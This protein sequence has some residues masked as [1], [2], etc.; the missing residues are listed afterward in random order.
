M[1]TIFSYLVSPGSGKEGTLEHE[2]TAINDPGK[3]RDMLESVFEGADDE[4]TTPIAFS[5]PNGDQS[6]DTRT[7]LIGAIKSPTEA[8]GRS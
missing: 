8:S 6:N 5:S 1:I 4:C 7:E 2:G 3:L